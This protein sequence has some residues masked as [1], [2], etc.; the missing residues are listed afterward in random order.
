MFVFKNEK[1][2]DEFEISG[3]TYEP[4]GD[5]FYGGKVKLNIKSRNFN[6]RE[7]DWSNLP[8][9]SNFGEENFVQKSGIRIP[10]GEDQIFCHYSFF[11]YLFHFVNKKL[12]IKT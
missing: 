10:V 3:S 7:L 1:D 9:N 2:L 12:N 6:F 4:I 8:Q 5:V 11:L